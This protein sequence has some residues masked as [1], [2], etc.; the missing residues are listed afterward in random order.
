M[1]KPTKHFMELHTAHNKIGRNA[2]ATVLKKWHQNKVEVQI[3]INK[4][5]YNKL[6]KYTQLCKDLG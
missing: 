3:S 4:L 6:L 1:E 5:A 2:L